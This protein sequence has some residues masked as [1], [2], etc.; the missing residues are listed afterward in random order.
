MRYTATKLV[1]TDTV[2]GEDKGWAKNGGGRRRTAG[3]QHHLQ[4]CGED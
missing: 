3:N 4:P 1:V 2:S